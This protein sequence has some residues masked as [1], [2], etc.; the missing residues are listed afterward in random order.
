[1]NKHGLDGLLEKE[2]ILYFDRVNVGFSFWD[3]SYHLIS[4][5]N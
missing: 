2:E 3:W 5:Y 4:D 1:M